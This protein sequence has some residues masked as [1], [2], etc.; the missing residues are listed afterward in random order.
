MESPRVAS[1]P[2]RP[3]P[4]QSAL[5]QRLR[6][7]LQAV[8]LLVPRKPRLSCGLVA[9]LLSICAAPHPAWALDEG[10]LVP[11]SIQMTASG[12][13]IDITSYAKKKN[14][15]NLFLFFFR[16][17]T[18]GICLAQLV[19]I[20]R[21]LDQLEQN[22]TAVLAVSL[23]DAIVQSQ[24]SERIE[25]KYPIL[26]DPDAKLVKAF[27]TFNPEEKLSFPA[28]FLIGSDRKI[29]F[30]YVGKAP[31]DRPPM[32]K[33]LEVSQHYSGLMPTNPGR[34]TAGKERSPVRP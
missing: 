5:R 34:A 2:K 31:R 11:R 26:M 6:K 13:K 3:P 30:K 16:T 21:S 25:K 12:E 32:Q 20:A 8:P 28:T 18:C 27:G 10:Q 19:E 4:Q 14:K 29:L 7:P 22:N 33:L 24:V 1:C 9:F 17:G 23:D 15:R